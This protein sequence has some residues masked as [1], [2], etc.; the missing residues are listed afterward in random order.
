MSPRKMIPLAALIVILAS[1]LVSL[2]EKT[3]QAAIQPSAQP[4]L[5]DPLINGFASFLFPGWGQ[6]LNGEREKKFLVHASI[7]L[8]LTLILIYRWGTYDG[9]LARVGRILWGVYS[10]FE[11]HNTCFA[12][13]GSQR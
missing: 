4:V 8:G 3:A 6:Y 13:L 9:N 11:A 5:C 7:G 10:G 1:A 12:M 2:D